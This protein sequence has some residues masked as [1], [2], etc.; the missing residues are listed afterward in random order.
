MD[1]RPIF[2]ATIPRGEPDE[3][4]ALAVVDSQLCVTIELDGKRRSVLLDRSDGLR[5]ADAVSRALRPEPAAPVE[6][7]G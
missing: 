3:G 4:L 5:M 6:A 7:A 2:R 1:V